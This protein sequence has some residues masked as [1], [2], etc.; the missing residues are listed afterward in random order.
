MLGV[1]SQFEDYS[2][3]DFKK[4]TEKVVSLIEEEAEVPH[5]YRIKVIVKLHFTRKAPP[6]LGVSA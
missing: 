6:R 5:P 2:D 3:E 1:V 4:L